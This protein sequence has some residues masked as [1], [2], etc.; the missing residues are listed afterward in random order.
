MFEIDYIDNDA[1]VRDHCH[2]TR[3]YRSSAH[4]DCNISLK[5]NEL[6]KYMN[7]TINNKFSFIDSFQFLSSSL[8]SSVKDLNKN[9]FK[10][11]SQAFDN[12]VL[13]QVK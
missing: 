7:F 10:Y 1:K 4:R 2:I 3:K 8:D 13:D 6:E 12:N 11:L 9:D 5:L